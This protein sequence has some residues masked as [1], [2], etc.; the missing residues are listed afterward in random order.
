[1][2]ETEETLEYVKRELTAKMHSTVRC[3]VLPSYNSTNLNI[4]RTLFH[5]RA[6]TTFIRMEWKSPT[7]H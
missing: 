7:S 1:M 6:T 2:A 3:K 5:S 4:H